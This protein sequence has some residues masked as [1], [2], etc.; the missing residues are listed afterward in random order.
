MTD[1]D[2]VNFELVN[3]SFQNFGLSSH[4]LAQNHRYEQYATHSTQIKSKYSL[5]LAAPRVSI[6]LILILFTSS[7]CSAVK[8]WLPCLAMVI[9]F[10]CV[11]RI[12]M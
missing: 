7:L 3:V 8:K 6:I 2:Q 11:L 10:S 1:L 4:L 5:L 12:F 9:Q